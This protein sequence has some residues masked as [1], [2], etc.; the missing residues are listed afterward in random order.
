MIF[1]TSETSDVEPYDSSRF[2][3]RLWKSVGFGSGSIQYLAQILNKIKFLQNLALFFV[4]SIIFFPKVGLLL[5]IFGLF[6]PFYVES[7]PTGIQIRSRM[8]N[9]NALRVR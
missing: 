4:R 8:R 5:L 3:Y 6:I 1:K 9:P 2:W 7:V